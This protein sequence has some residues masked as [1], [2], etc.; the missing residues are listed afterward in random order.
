[1]LFAA[2]TDVMQRIIPNRAVVLVALAGLMLRWEDGVAALLLALLLAAVIF[3]AMLVLFQLE[4]VGGG[5]VKLLAA[6]SLLSEPGA[7]PG[8]LLLIAM[9]GGVLALLWI[10]DRRLRG[11]TA[12][13]VDADGAELDLLTPPPPETE[14]DRAQL[15]E[16]G[17]PYG[18]AICFGTIVSMA[19]SS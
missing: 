14:P 19:I 10:I 3:A 11:V 5:D 12:L 2:I 15:Q 1:M 13:P 8:Q 16:H 17:L 7:V 9:A 6:A 4:I 18:V